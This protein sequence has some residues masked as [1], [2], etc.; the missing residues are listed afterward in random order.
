MRCPDVERGGEPAGHR[1]HPQV[2]LQRLQLVGQGLRD[3]AGAQQPGPARGADG[4]CGDGAALEQPQ[5][6]VVVEPELDVLRPVEDLAGLLRE[7][8]QPAQF[9]GAEERLGVR[10]F[11]AQHAATGLSQ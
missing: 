9:E 10:R 4:H 5:P 2:L 1:G 11:R 7:A 8:G 3:R 6:A